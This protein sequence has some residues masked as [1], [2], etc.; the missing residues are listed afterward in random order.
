MERIEDFQVLNQIGRG[1]FASVYRAVCGADGKVTIHSRLKH[2]AILELIAYFEVVSG[3]IYLHS[4]GIMHRDLTLA[5][6]MLTHDMK[7]KI[8]DFG[9]ATQVSNAQDRHVTMCGTPNYISPEVATRSSHGLEADIWGLGCLLYTLLVGTP[10]FD[11]SGVRS[12]LTKVVMADYQLPS[13]LSHE[14]A[15]LIASMLRKNPNERVKLR[16]IPNHPWFRI[17]QMSSSSSRPGPRPLQ[18]FPMRSVPEHSVENEKGIVQ[19]SPLRL[20]HRGSRDKNF[21]LES[22]YGKGVEEFW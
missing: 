1:G 21:V 4:H 20:E 5:N 10:P 13:H 19:K 7:V 16:D 3:L 12:T 8:G 22:V 11:T 18:A 15:D 9:L 14:A 6:L 17:H 2:P